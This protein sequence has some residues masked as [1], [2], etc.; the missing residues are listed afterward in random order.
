MATTSG[1]QATALAAKAAEQ[2]SSID[3]GLTAGQIEEMA[4]IIGDAY[5]PAMAVV[6]KAR[7]FVKDGNVLTL[8]ELIHELGKLDASG[9]E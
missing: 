7:A 5:A 8:G 2:C 4:R 9:G 6:E 3:A 1:K